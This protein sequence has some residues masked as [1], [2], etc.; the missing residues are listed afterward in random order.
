MRHLYFSAAARLCC[1]A[2]CRLLTGWHSPCAVLC[3]A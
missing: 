1:A 3:I 2:C